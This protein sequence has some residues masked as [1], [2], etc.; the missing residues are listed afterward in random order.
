MIA[1]GLAKSSLGIWAGTRTKQQQS[2]N[3]TAICHKDILNLLQATPIVQHAGE[4][5]RLL[6]QFDG[7]RKRGFTPV[8][9]TQRGGAKIA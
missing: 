5:P 2:A 8:V 3:F 9:P 4:F 1:G 7:R 6:R